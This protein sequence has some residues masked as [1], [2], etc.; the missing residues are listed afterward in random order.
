MCNQYQAIKKPMPQPLRKAGFGPQLSDEEVIA[1][2]LCGEMFKMP[3]D[4][5]LFA[6][7]CSFLLCR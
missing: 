1:I 7:D 5:D 3:K 4:K 2:E 6:F